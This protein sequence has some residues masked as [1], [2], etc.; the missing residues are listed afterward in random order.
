MTG[1]PQCRCE[2][3]LCW[4]GIP[5]G[6]Q[7]F[8]VGAIS[9]GL[10]CERPSGVHLLCLSV[11]L[12]VP[13]DLAPQPRELSELPGLCLLHDHHFCQSWLGSLPRG[14]A[15]ALPSLLLLLLVVLSRGAVPLGK[16]P[17]AG[18]ACSL[19]QPQW[20]CGAPAARATKP[21]WVDHTRAPC[22]FSGLVSIAGNAGTRFG[23]TRVG[24][25]PA[26]SFTIPQGV[27][28]TSLVSVPISFSQLQDVLDRVL[29]SKDAWLLSSPGTGLSEE[30]Q[31][32]QEHG[33]MG[34]PVQVRDA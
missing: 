12:E 11:L 23:D 26:E 10:P 9:G 20:L 15:A 2:D 28:G 14:L 1:G 17:S 27:L 32:R 33:V 30:T 24:A 25:G 29:A 34:T 22:A 31:S 16:L 19:Q 7:G 5:S 3:G 4:L 18:L 6:Q 13:W 21:S 8:E